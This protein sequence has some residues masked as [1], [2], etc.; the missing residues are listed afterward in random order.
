MTTQEFVKMAEDIAKGTPVYYAYGFTGQILSVAAINAK[1][2]Q[3]PEW[4]TDAR[5]KELKKHIG[6]PACDCSGLIKGMLREELFPDFNADHI[7]NVYCVKVDKPYAGC[8]AHKKGHIGIVI[9]DTEVVEASSSKGKVVISNIKD[10]DF[11]EYGVFVFLKE[12]PSTGDNLLED[13]KAL[14]KKYGG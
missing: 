13:L 11:T 7:F 5:I 8:L 1:A 10:R 3:Y 6:Y 4:Y 2:K 12:T 14:I 9:N